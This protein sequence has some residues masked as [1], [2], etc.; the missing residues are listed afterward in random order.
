MEVPLCGHA[1]I[2]A[3]AALF[4]GAGNAAVELLFDTV[5]SF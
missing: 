2:A 1:T 3:A 5:R 4:S